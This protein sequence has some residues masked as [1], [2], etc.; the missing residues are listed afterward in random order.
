M[1]QKSAAKPR[2]RTYSA[3]HNGLQLLAHRLHGRRLLWLIFAAVAMGVGAL[4]AN[5]PAWLSGVV[6]DRLIKDPEGAL[7]AVAPLLLMLLMSY[8]ARELAILAR[9]YW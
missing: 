6:V 9:K 1:K 7:T 5:L 8:V 3:T 2:N 4:A